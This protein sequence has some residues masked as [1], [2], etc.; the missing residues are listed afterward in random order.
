MYKI[1]K[2]IEISAAHSLDH[3]DYDSKCKSEHG[4]N[5]IITIYCQRERLDKNGMVIDFV[6]IKEKIGHLD[7]SNLNHHIKKPTAENIAEYILDRIPFCYKVK[8]QES[9]GNVA[10]YEV[11]Y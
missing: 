9:R 8:V 2:T 4:H 10:I 5:Y 3:L 6:D 1:E 11:S 7:H